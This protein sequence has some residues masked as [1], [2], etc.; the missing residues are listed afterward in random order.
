MYPNSLSLVSLRSQEGIAGVFSNYE[1]GRKKRQ[2][3]WHVAWILFI[4]VRPFT[5]N[6]W[7]EISFLAWG[8]C[9][10]PVV[11]ESASIM[12]WR[13]IGEEDDESAKR[14]ENCY[15]MTFGGD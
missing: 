1:V 15:A 10:Y 12:G 8:L 6:E 9:L 3:A 14:N 13:L 11:R 4:I 2:S 5:N 7:Q